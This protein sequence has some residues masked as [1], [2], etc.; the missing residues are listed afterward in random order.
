MKCQATS[1]TKGFSPPLLTS[2][3]ILTLALIY[4]IVAFGFGG[5]DVP[6]AQASRALPTDLSYSQETTWLLPGLPSL[7]ATAG[8]IPQNLSQNEPILHFGNQTIH[9]V[10]PGTAYS[11]MSLRSLAWAMEPR[12]G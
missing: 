7:S 11:N 4:A 12:P 2:G 9:G 6:L 10:L 5:Q 1:K 8:T 3:Y